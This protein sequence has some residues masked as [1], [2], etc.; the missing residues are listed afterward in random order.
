MT[1]PSSSNCM[2]S[3][4]CPKCLTIP[5]KS[6]AM[7][8]TSWSFLVERRSTTWRTGSEDS[9]GSESRMA[10]MCAASVCGKSY[11]LARQSWRAINFDQGDI[12]RRTSSCN[13]SSSILSR[14]SSIARSSMKS[15]KVFHLLRSWLGRVSCRL[16]DIFPLSSDPASSLPASDRGLPKTEE[17]VTVLCNDGGTAWFPSCSRIASSDRVRWERARS[18]SW[19]ELRHCWLA[20]NSALTLATEWTCSRSNS[21]N[22]TILLAA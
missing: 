21:R 7:A 12:F 9:C 13:L 16:V 4:T 15:R 2:A 17:P 1:P 8:W 3:L 19:V 14:A 18:Q 20:I 5:S 22:L 6:L 10:V 11:V